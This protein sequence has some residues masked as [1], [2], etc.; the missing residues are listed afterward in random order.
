HIG[1]DL[2][3]AIPSWGILDIYGRFFN[4][5]HDTTT[6]FGY[7]NHPVNM[8]DLEKED[9]VEL[10][11]NPSSHWNRA[12]PPIER[13]IQEACRRYGEFTEFGM[14]SFLSVGQPAEDTA[15]PDEFDPPCGS[16]HHNRLYGMLDIKNELPEKDDLVV[17]DDDEPPLAPSAS[18]EQFL[19]QNTE[20]PP[21]TVTV[22]STISAP[23]HTT[24]SQASKP[25][26]RFVPR[27][28]DMRSIVD[29]IQD[30]E[31]HTLRLEAKLDLLI[32]HL[33]PGVP[34]PGNEQ[35]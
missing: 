3:L 25:V 10:M 16:N 14:D 28:G 11:S 31:N 18:L 1:G 13:V 35:G 9:F 6:K 4:R 33:L 2:N 24:P 32:Q 19:A 21:A 5:I 30:L 15:G 17:L 34:I 22:T 26:P 27:D 12:S 7:L 20:I 29:R 8:M 23:V